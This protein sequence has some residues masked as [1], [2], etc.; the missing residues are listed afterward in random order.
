MQ[1]QDVLSLCTFMLLFASLQTC[2]SCRRRNVIYFDGRFYK[3]HGGSRKQ[4]T[5]HNKMCQDC[6]TGYNPEKKEKIEVC[7]KHLDDIKDIDED[8]PKPQPV[9]KPH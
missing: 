2:R 1:V 5:E 4:R 6:A 3:C 8:M 9:L 7:W